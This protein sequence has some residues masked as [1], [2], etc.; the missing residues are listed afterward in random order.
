MVELKLKS[1]RFRQRG[2][3][4]D[5]SGIA[6]LSEKCQ[7]E[8]IQQFFFAKMRLSPGN[9]HLHSRCRRDGAWRLQMGIIIPN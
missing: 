2:P 3:N 4:V 1:R 7:H 6:G 8:I 5:E 9:A